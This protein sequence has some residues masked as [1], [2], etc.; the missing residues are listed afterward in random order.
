MKHLSDVVTV[1]V[2]LT[3]IMSMI[4]GVLAQQRCAE[5]DKFHLFRLQNLLESGT[6]DRHLA[7]Y[8]FPE[9]SWNSIAEAKARLA[10]GEQ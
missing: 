6:S 1:L 10:A 4:S 7:M 2:A 3:V 9:F 5:W 8:Y